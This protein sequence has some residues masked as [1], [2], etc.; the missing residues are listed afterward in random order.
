MSLSPHSHG[1]AAGAAQGSRTGGI[2][3]GPYVDEIRR[4]LLWMSVTTITT[5]QK[6]LWT[7]EK[8]PGWLARFVERRVEMRLHPARRGLTLQ[9]LLV[10]LGTVRS[11]GAASSRQPNIYSIRETK[12]ADTVGQCKHAAGS[13]RC[14]YFMRVFL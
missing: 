13:N 4:K 2:T 11:P 3:S 6:K 8:K 5:S 10:G 1:V 14:Q 7:G 9:L 12:K